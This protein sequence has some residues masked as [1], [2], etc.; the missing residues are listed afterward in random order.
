MENVF[1]FWKN[2]E[3]KT[4]ELLPLQVFPA[5]VKKVDEETRTCTVRVN[6]NVDLFDVKLYAVT[7]K[8][9]KGFCLIPAQDSQVLVA[10]IANG[11]DL[12][13]CMFSVVD[14][15]L[16][17]IGKH[18][19]LLVEE[20]HIQLK[21][22]Q[23]K[24]EVTND[25]IKVDAPEITFKGSDNVGLLTT[26]EL[27]DKIN[28]LVDAFNEHMHSSSVTSIIAPSGTTGGACS[29]ELEMQKPNKQAEK[30]QEEPKE[31]TQDQ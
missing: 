20:E 9:L 16:G 18:T 1:K 22:E 4:Q 8:D 31:K 30:L 23:V 10:R 21:T 11:N 26:A 28:A 15:V 14:K 13:V 7:D 12:Y 17:T 6:D 29:G 3:R 25:K 24:I 2:V 19:D 5:Q 27:T